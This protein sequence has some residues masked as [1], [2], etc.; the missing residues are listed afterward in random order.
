MM[1]TKLNTTLITETAHP[2]KRKF[3]YSSNTFKSAKKDEDAEP[4]FDR[5]KIKKEYEK[6]SGLNFDLIDDKPPANVRT[7]DYRKGQVQLMR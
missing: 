5:G 3:L 1:T 2:V 6:A 4:S 7:S